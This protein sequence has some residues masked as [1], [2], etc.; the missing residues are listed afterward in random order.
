[1][2]EAP[3]A[4]FRPLPVTPTTEAL[5]AA[6]A[7]VFSST[8]CSGGP[9]SA[10]PA[11]GPKQVGPPLRGGGRCPP[12]PPFPQWQKCQGQAEGRSESGESGDWKGSQ[13]SAGAKAEEAQPGQRAGAAA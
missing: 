1:M 8:C 12:T 5:P 6:H 10:L 9:L 2:A 3:E 7:Q 4:E 11:L 13:G